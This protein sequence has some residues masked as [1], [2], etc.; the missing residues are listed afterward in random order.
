MFNRCNPLALIGDA[1]A[2]LENAHVRPIAA[3]AQIIVTILGS[4]H[5]CL[6]SARASFLKMPFM[7]KSEEIQILP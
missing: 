1:D 7:S 5:K 2:D 4:A 6:Q 3:N